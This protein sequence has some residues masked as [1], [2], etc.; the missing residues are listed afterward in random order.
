MIAPIGTQENT[1]GKTAGLKATFARTDCPPG[2]E[3]QRNRNVKQLRVRLR[4]WLH[5][6]GN[7]SAGN[8]NNQKPPYIQTNK[9][10]TQGESSLHLLN[11]T[12]GVIKKCVLHLLYV[13]IIRTHL[14]GSNQNFFPHAAVRV[15]TANLIC[16]NLAN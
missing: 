16:F 5:Y 14:Q 7:S 11:L 1:F 15:F 13:L 6:A 12:R 4:H 8:T 2:L 9:L 3:S 10:T